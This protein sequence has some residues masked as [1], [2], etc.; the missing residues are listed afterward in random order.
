MIIDLGGCPAIGT[1]IQVAVN[2]R[3][4][5]EISTLTTNR[6]CAG[7][8]ELAVH[9]TCIPWKKRHVRD[10]DKTDLHSVTAL[11]R[12]PIL[13]FISE[14]LLWFSEYSHQHYDGTQLEVDQDLTKVLPDR[15]QHARPREFTVVNFLELSTVAHILDGD[16]KRPL[17]LNPCRLLW[18]SKP[19]PAGCVRFAVITIDDGFTCRKVGM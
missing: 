1:Q 4:V 8:G 19:L 15:L 2:K 10:I 16:S 14:C 17:A 5:A 9:I 12:F 7:G 3:E 6:G 18:L 11:T 13:T